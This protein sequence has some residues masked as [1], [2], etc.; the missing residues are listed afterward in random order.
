[1][2][3]QLISDNSLLLSTRQ[4]ILQSMKYLHTVF[5]TIIISS[6]TIS[7][8][9]QIHIKAVGDI[10]MGSYTPRTI[11]PPN[12]GQ[13]FIDSIAPYLD[14]SSITFGNI[15]G[16]FVT[17]AL[18]PR[19][20]RPESRKAGRCYEFGMPYTLSNTLK[21]LNIT[22]ASLDNNHVSDYGQEGIN[23]T[24]KRLDS[25]DIQYAG[26]KQPIMFTID[27]IKFA[28]IA[29]GTSGVSWRVSDLNNAKKVIRKY[30]TIVDIVL[31]SFHG[32]AE[33]FSA[34]HTPNHTETYYGED[35]GNLIAFS[36]TAIDAGADLI[37]GHGPHVLRGLELY[38]NKLICYSL[39]NFL[40]YGNVSLKGVK[41]VGAIMDIVID[42]KTG[43]FLSGDIIPTKQLPPGIP[44]FDN[45]GEAIT[46]LQN[47]SKEDFPQSG[48][49]ISNDG[50]LLNKP[51]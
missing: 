10:M 26:K 14:S 2:A 22:H 19:K 37:I 45:H 48:L 51:K 30:D 5:F 29:F 47:L 12:N 16:V 31:V 33:G 9:A 23:F 7:S 3:L 4:F 35:R 6:L 13:V 11:I 36:H 24:K 41:G 34:Q 18:T 40:T 38:N 49:I 46:I 21:E 43:D 50:S 32:G 28:L 15:E 42:N 44:Y 17:K 27:S 25:L 20:C 8:S 39:G 1:M